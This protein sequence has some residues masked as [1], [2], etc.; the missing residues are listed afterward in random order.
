MEDF[1]IFFRSSSDSVKGSC[2][3]NAILCYL[4][5]GGALYPL[6]L[7]L[8][9][10]ESNNARYFPFLAKL[11]KHKGRL[12]FLKEGFWLTANNEADVPRT[13]R[14]L[15]HVIHL[16]KTPHHSLQKVKL[17][18]KTVWPYFFPIQPFGSWMEKRVFFFS[19]WFRNQSIAWRHVWIGPIEWLNIY[20]C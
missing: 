8:C 6:L 9:V 5:A 20:K 3:E 18:W 17:Q 16:H 15:R 2:K 10:R 1:Y 12:P 4:F 14:T 7:F 19:I 11:L 13:L